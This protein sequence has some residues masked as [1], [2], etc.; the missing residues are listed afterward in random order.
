MLRAKGNGASFWGDEH[1]LKLTIM[2]A[3]LCDYTKSHGS[4]QVK[5][6]N[7][8]VHELYRKAV[9]CFKYL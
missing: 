8:M 2:M 3:A 7:W 4:V 9:V 5:W 6:V 1:V